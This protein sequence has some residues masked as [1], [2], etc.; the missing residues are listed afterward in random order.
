MTFYSSGKLQFTI[1]IPIIFTVLGGLI[2]VT[3]GVITGQIS[4]SAL[5]A[6]TYASSRS[7]IRRLQHGRV[8]DVHHR[9]AR[10]ALASPLLIA[11]TQAFAWGVG[12]CVL[13]IVSGVSRNSVTM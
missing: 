3:A 2:P 8:S 13:Y 6:T 7:H 10:S 5:I 9:G 1:L 4:P 11:L 12:Q